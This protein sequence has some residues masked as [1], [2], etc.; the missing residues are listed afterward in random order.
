MNKG[1]L[2]GIRVV[3][4]TSVV[5]GPYGTQA[6]ADMGADVIKIEPP[7]G[8]ITRGLSPARHAG[9]S[10][11]FININRNK[12]S[13]VLDITQPAGRA[14]L[15]EIVRGADV[16]VH[17]LRPVAIRK[18]GIDYDDV[19]AVNPEIVYAEAL[20]FGSDGP[21]SGRPAYD[22]VI[23]A[24]SGF[25]DL[26]RRQ[27]RGQPRLAPT[28]IA[29]KMAGMALAIAM[30]L[31]L[32]HRLRTGQGQR[33]EVPMYEA[34]VAD[35][36][37]E[38]LSG[39][40]F[41]PPLP[42][43]ATAMGHRRALDEHRK[44]HR[45]QDGYLSV[46]PYTDRHWQAFFAAI[47]RA[48]LAADPKFTRYEERSRNLSELYAMV[49]DVM[50]TRTTADWSVAMDKADIPHFPIRT[51]EELLDDPHLKA[52]G[53]F[54]EYEHPTQGRIR[55]T[56]VTTKLSVSP[57]DAL[58]RPAPLLGEHSH[59]VLREAGLSEPAIDALRRAGATLGAT[60]AP[61]HP[62]EANP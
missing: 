61:L 3:D 33:V 11:L 29:D 38:H 55:T 51:L 6:M 43:R 57:G 4:L 30:L 18:L 56:A 39:A 9:M 21:Y 22:D 2:A 62:T 19:R 20:G 16:F 41:E 59:E 36:L 17:N 27:T 10:G 46:L 32:I 54:Q 31:A 53:F 60:A 44:P 48:D 47:G 52:V 40:V 12:R 34:F 35:T 13:V 45:T 50:P 7:E 58:R 15:L 28:V 42:D 1:A 49:A 26:V 23:Q 14:A 8:D 37:L 5:F 25:V 24:M